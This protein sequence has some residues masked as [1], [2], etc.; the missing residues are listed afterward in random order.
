MRCMS[1]PPVRP[2]SAE[3]SAK[4]FS[5]PDGAVMIQCRLEVK[6]QVTG[7]AGIEATHRDEWRRALR[8]SQIGG[9]I[10]DGLAFS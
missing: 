2:N 7:Q 1:R 9:D 5:K 8:V 3:Q 10:G 6:F 4:N